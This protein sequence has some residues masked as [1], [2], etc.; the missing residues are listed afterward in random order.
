METSSLSACKLANEMDHHHVL[1][2][3][4]R[5]I[6]HTHRLIFMLACRLID[7]VEKEVE[8]SIDAGILFLVHI[9]RIPISKG[10]D[11]IPKA[12]LLQVAFSALGR[13]ACKGRQMRQKIVDAGA[14]PA[15]VNKLDG[16][17]NIPQVKK[18]FR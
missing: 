11:Q 15:L 1:K 10:F 9:A 3:N 5:S 12:Y 13:L 6:P 4:A 17:F 18:S 8:S 2:A 16:P 7:V 14:I